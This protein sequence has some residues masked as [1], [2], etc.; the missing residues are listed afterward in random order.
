MPCRTAFEVSIL[1]TGEQR[2]ERE[3]ATAEG[4]VNSMPIVGKGAPWDLRGASQ[5]ENFRVVMCICWSK[6]TAV[7]EGLPRALN[8]LLD[9]HLAR[10]A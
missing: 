5:E 9:C 6:Q 4:D 8:I 7:N 1:G 3:A 10:T 2:G